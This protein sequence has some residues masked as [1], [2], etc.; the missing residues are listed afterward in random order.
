MSSKRE[1]EKNGKRGRERRNMGKMEIAP[2]A[3]L[4][5]PT[6]CFT[7]VFMYC[8]AWSKKR[9]IEC[10]RGK[11]E[12]LKKEK[13]KDKVWWQGS[14]YCLFTIANSAIEKEQ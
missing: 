8:M 2:I 3:F 9:E 5:L 4:P 14:S 6:R 12:K 7:L 13:K 10:A 11:E 1:G